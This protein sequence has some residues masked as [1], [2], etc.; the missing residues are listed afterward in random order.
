[1]HVCLTGMTNAHWMG[2]H[3][4]HCGIL[5]LAPHRGED[6]GSGYAYDVSCQST[7]NQR[8][9]EHFSQTCPCERFLSGYK[10]GVSVLKRFLIE[11]N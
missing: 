2:I 11:L 1:M 3:L 7:V 5:T 10:V 4:G 9:I 6:C 8:L